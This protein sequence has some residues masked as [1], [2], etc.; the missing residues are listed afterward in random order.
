MEIFQHSAVSALQPRTKNIFPPRP[1][2]PRHNIHL[3]EQFQF[4]QLPYNISDR[5]ITFIGLRFNKETA[6]NTD[7]STAECA[8]TLENADST[9]NSTAECAWT[10]ETANSTDNSTAEFPGTLEQQGAGHEARHCIGPPHLPA[11]PRA[12][13]AASAASGREGLAKV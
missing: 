6:D 9:D 10:L 5:R 8:W 4:A 11:F 3:A 1:L 13:R 7:N 2:R 12:A